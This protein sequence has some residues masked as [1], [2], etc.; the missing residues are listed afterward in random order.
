MISA[1]F[2]VRCESLLGPI[3]LPRSWVAYL[4]THWSAY[5]PC[6]RHRHTHPAYLGELGVE[7]QT[8]RKVRPT[9]GVLA[10]TVLCTPLRVFILAQVSQKSFLSHSLV[11]WFS[12]WNIP[13]VLLHTTQERKHG[14]KEQNQGSTRQMG[15]A[16]SNVKQGTLVIHERC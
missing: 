1:G 15:C 9:D 3:L 7:I 12:S 4:W 16:K 10:T 6:E 2:S 14:P 13:G 11:Q 5:E 8:V